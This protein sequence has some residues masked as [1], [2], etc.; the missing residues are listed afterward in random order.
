M[1]DTQTQ[2]C[3]AA[4][5]NLVLSR[6]CVVLLGGVMSSEWAGGKVVSGEAGVHRSARWRG[7][8]RRGGEAEAGGV[9]F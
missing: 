4:G 5:S 2:S 7:K 6:R 1:L 3:C 9:G 8:G